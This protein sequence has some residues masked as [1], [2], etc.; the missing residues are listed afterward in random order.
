MSYHVCSAYGG[1]SVTIKLLAEPTII[2]FFFILSRRSLYTISAQS[3]PSGNISIWLLRYDGGHIILY[4]AISENDFFCRLT[5]WG[6]SC[7]VIFL[8]V[9]TLL[10]NILFRPAIIYH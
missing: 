6:I 7:L 5:I 10:L 3:C 4:S 8:I 9:I 2:F 1:F